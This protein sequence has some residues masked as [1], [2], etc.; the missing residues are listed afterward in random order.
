MDKK[1]LTDTEQ[2]EPKSFIIVEFDDVGSAV[3]KMNAHG[4]TPMQLLL[5]GD[6]LQL[7]AKDQILAQEHAI[8]EQQEQE[9]IKVPD[10]K[11][12]ISRR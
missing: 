7:K 5:I 9:K 3:F 1:V 11:I 8:R 12:A 6:Y 4:V 10:S 2:E